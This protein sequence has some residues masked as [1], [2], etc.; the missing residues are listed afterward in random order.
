MTTTSSPLSS[1][2]E[3]LRRDGV[4]DS[5]GSFSLD[6]KRAWEKLAQLGK[7]N[8]QAWLL[9]I[10]QLAARVRSCVC[11]TQSRTETVVRL[12]EFQGWSREELD[13]AMACLGH[14][15]PGEIRYLADAIRLLMGEGRPFWVGGR[16]GRENWNGEDFQS[17]PNRAEPNLAIATS[18]FEVGQWSSIV[19]WHN[20]EARKRL[21]TI[22]EQLQLTSCTSPVPVKLDNRDIVGILRDPHFGYSKRSRPLEFW[23]ASPSDSLPKFT[24]RTGGVGGFTDFHQGS[25]FAVP[26]N[27]SY[28]AGACG[29]LSC[30]M[31]EVRHSKGFSFVPRS[32]CSELVWLTD[33]AVVRRTRLPHTGSVALSIYVSAEGLTTDLSGIAIREDS[34]FAERRQ[35]ALEAAHQWLQRDWGRIKRLK[36][37]DFLESLTRHQRTQHSRHSR[38]DWDLLEELIGGVTSAAAEGYSKAKLQ[39]DV[40]TLC[41]FDFSNCLNSY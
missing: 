38:W 26:R 11:V 37:T 33:G 3:D 31:K 20:L 34:L 39:S 15:S 17:E 30:F 9:R 7:A 4:A 21:L 19:S 23:S 6:R 12:T 24:L 18:H 13:Q 8:P 27:R 25:A 28:T 41:D 14:E 40:D 22:Q 10:L 5:E 32:R 29:F 16:H 35:Q 36:L 1:L 2:L